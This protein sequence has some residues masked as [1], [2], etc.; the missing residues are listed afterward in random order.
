[1]I[2]IAHISKTYGAGPRAT[3]ALREVDLDL[4]RGEFVVLYGA[5]GSGKST[6][7]N[8][9]SGLD[10][11]TAGKIYFEA[12]EVTAMNETQLTILRRDKIGFVFQFFNL[13]PTLSILENVLLPAQLREHAPRELHDRALAL[14]ERLGIR[15]RYEAFPDQLSGGQ[16]QRVA[17]A[18]ALINA[19][20]L[21]LAD[22]PTGNLDSEN[23]LNILHLLK[24]LV[25]QEKCTVL[26]ATHSLEAAR[27]ADR[28]YQVRDGKIAA[29]SAET[30]AAR[31]GA[32]RVST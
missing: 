1:M 24:Q 27:F 28:L 18:R 4:A 5:S 23:G 6:L 32:W 17:I 7:L 26:M 10:R 16:Q 19:P 21:L 30:V 12:Q 25:Q 20:S 9:I 13:L 15:E 3:H 11:P 31:E 14:L 22:E 8:L 2:R 29:L